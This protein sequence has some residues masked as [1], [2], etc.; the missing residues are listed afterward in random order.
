MKLI[1]APIAALFLVGCNA[2]GPAPIPPTAT[3]RPPAP[4]SAKPPERG[5]LTTIEIEQIFELRLKD[6][7][8]MVDVRRGIFHQ[9]GHIRGSVH[10]PLTDFEASFP[11]VKPQLDDAA[12]AGKVIVVYCQDR[13]CPD[14]HTAAEALVE[15]GYDVSIYPGGWDEWKA[16]GID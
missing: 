12:A 4:V 2:P 5:R 1:A 11:K 10:L 3:P 9:L 8:L 13:T 16:L 14:S 6:Q 7:V 15:R